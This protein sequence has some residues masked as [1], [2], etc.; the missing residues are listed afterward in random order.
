MSAIYSDIS[1]LYFAYLWRAFPQGQS[2]FSPPQVEKSVQQIGAWV[3]LESAGYHPDNSNI[4]KLSPKNDC[5]WTFIHIHFSTGSLTCAASIRSGSSSSSATQEG[6]RGLGEAGG[7]KT[8][9]ATY[10]L[11]HTFACLHTH[12][13]AFVFELYRGL[14]MALTPQVVAA[15]WGHSVE[16]RLD[17][18]G[19]AHW[20]VQSSPCQSYCWSTN[21]EGGA[22]KTGPAFLTLLPHV[23]TDGSKTVRGGG[24]YGVPLGLNGTI[25]A[26]EVGTSLA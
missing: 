15:C 2:F 17:N 3:P 4:Y 21:E 20:W 6:A 9:R 7:S 18:S 1:D 8:E 12:I 26:T 25:W 5:I 10:T 14:P 16:S 11:T 19:L 24:M 13:H 22:K 23:T